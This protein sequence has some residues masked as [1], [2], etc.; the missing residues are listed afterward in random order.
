M[1]SKRVI[2]QQFHHITTNARVCGINC[3][4]FF[5]YKF[6]LHKYD[7]NPDF[8]LMENR[9]IWKYTSYVL[10]QIL[11]YSLHYVYEMST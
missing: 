2:R 11:L 8:V 6:T 4:R 1:N 9:V 5:E 7:I 10:P 3:M